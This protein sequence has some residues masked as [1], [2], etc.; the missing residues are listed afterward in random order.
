[1]AQAEEGELDFIVRGALVPGV[2]LGLRE[3]P[4]SF[5]NLNDFS[6]MVKNISPPTPNLLGLRKN[7]CVLRKVTRFWSMCIFS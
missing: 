7:Q 2:Y 5:P 6:K 3:F 4:K 1:M